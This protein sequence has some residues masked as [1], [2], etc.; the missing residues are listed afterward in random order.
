MSVQLADAT[1][2]EKPPWLRFRR[3]APFAGA[4]IFLIAMRVV[5]RELR[6]FHYHEVAAYLDVLPNS[7]IA[8]AI[9]GAFGSYFAL[10]LVDLLAVRGSGAPAPTWGGWAGA[11]P[12]GW[13]FGG[14]V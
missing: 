5:V 4:L 9:L 14:A 11:P 12:R 1:T 13:R 6:S 10:M 3:I 8:F 2:H 7:R